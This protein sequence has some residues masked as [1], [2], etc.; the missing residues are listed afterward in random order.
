M[1]CWQPLHDH[2]DIIGY[3]AATLVL[4]TF[5]MRTMVPL[6]VLGL[7]SNV[8]FLAYGLAEGLM[9]ILLLHM[10]LVPINLYRLEQ[11]PQVRET[12]WRLLRHVVPGRSPPGPD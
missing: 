8:A 11:I 7:A 1:S 9:P 6:R 12:L 2:A 4:L 10:L 5:L 3:A